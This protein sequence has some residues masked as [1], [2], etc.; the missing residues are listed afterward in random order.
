MINM[1]YY[2]YILYNALLFLSNPMCGVVLFQ[3]YP[4]FNI[5]IGESRGEFYTEQSLRSVVQTHP[6]S[7]LRC[8]LV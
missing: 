4:M 5:G 3:R 6:N 7:Y 2:V 8:N 1:V